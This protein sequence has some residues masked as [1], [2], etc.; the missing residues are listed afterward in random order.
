SIG[1]GLEP[2]AVLVARVCC[3]GVR[4]PTISRIATLVHKAAERRYRSLPLRLAYPY[5]ADDETCRFVRYW[6]GDSSR[7][8]LAS[9]AYGISAVESRR[10]Q[11]LLWCAFSRLII[12]K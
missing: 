11:E 6:F 2:L 10:I 9:L 1:F 8:Q 12:T 5:Q 3:S 7:R 4:Q